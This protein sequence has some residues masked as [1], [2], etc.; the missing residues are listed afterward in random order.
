MTHSHRSPVT[1]GLLPCP[2][3]GK[4][5]TMEQ[6]EGSRWSVGCD[7]ADEIAC[8]GYQNFTTFARRSDAVKAWNTRATQPAAPTGGEAATNGE[9]AG[10][11]EWPHCRCL[12]AKRCSAGTGEPV[13]WVAT[14]PD[15]GLNF[16]TMAE[17]QQGATSRL[18][19]TGLSGD[20][21]WAIVPLYRD[22]AQPAGTSRN[23]EESGFPKISSDVKLVA[24][25]KEF[26]SEETKV[27]RNHGTGEVSSVELSTA[28]QLV[29]RALLSLT[30]TNGDT[31]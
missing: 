30:S 27:W 22:D 25:M 1:T 13:A 23:S 11:C 29:K 15:R 20:H 5:A 18:M 4:S 16:G 10:K 31:Q 8:M 28:G 21:G 9:A 12:E 2:F 6:T 3:C 14:H 26:I 19:M 7:A 17:T 24:D